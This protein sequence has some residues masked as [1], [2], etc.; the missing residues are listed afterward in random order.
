AKRFWA[1]IRRGLLRE[2]VDRIGLG[3]Y[4]HLVEGYPDF[5]ETVRQITDEFRILQSFHENDKPYAAPIKVAVLTAWGK[6]RSWVYVGHF[7]EGM[8]LYELTESLAGLPVD[9]TFISFEDILKSGIPKDC[10]VIINAGRLDNAWTGGEHWKNEKVIEAISSWIAEGGGFIGIGEP[11]ACRHS[12]QYFQLSHILGVDRETGQTCGKPK[13]NY[14]LTEQ[15]HF[16]LEDTEGDIDFGDDIDDVYIVDKDTH[17]L[18]DKDQSPKIALN[19]FGKGQ[20]IY[21]SGFKFSPQNTRLL[22]RC[23]FWAAGRQSDF[24]PWTTSNINTDCAYY[25]KG[26]KLVVINS[27]E[28]AQ[29]TKVLDAKGNSID[30]SLEPYGIKIMEM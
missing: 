11:S 27:D 19:S 7:I 18:A 3:G 24:G 4:L 2:P 15:K 1:N 10:H 14:T 29:K 30:V 13:R 6:L 28:K 22:Y 25:P 20:S 9:V 8:E 17:V 26:K 21:L 12:S 16:I 23:L 5:I